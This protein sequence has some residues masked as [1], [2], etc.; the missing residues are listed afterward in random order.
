M[1]QFLD[2]TDADFE[3]RFTNLLGAKREDSPDVDDVVASII[4]DV[5]ARAR[6]FFL[7][8]I[9]ATQV[10]DSTLHLRLEADSSG[11][12][13]FGLAGAEPR[14]F[15]QHRSQSWGAARGSP[16]HPMGCAE[17]PL[18]REQTTFQ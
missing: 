11:W 15:A 4:K 10:L 16:H 1:P 3:A 2:T 8:L 7:H 9:L 17:F 14:C 5:R 13:G 6:A 12:L 18:L